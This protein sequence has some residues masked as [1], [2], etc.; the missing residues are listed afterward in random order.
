MILKGNEIYFIFLLTRFS[1]PRICRLQCRMIELYIRIINE[2]IIN[3]AQYKR[4]QLWRNLRYYRRICL[5]E[6][7]EETALG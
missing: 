1:V 2:I 7:R 4:K 5:S 6:L 3:Y